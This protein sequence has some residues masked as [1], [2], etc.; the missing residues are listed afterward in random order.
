MGEERL[1]VIIPKSAG[2]SHPP[3]F[4]VD[5]GCLSAKQTVIRT[6]VRQVIFQHRTTF[7]TFAPT[8]NLYSNIGTA[9]PNAGLDLYHSHAPN[10]PPSGNSGGHKPNNFIFLLQFLLCRTRS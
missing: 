3:I 5:T 10:S 2:D 9:L 8:N 4:F 7:E 6:R 1:A